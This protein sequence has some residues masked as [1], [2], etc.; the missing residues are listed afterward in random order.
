MVNTIERVEGHYEVQEVELGRVYRWCPEYVLIDCDCGE[1]MTLTSSTTTCWRCGLDHSA[2]LEEE[3]TAQQLKDETLHP[4]RYVR[5]R[6]DAGLP[7]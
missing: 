2:L 6:E 1:R 7:C 5:D 3:V 4:W